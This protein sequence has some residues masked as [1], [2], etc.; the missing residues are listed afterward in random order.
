[1]SDTITLEGSGYP[2]DPREDDTQL[3]LNQL[4][5]YVAVTVIFVLLCVAIL[6]KYRYTL[7]GFV[8]NRIF[9]RS[10]PRVRYSRMEMDA[11]V[12]NRIQQDETPV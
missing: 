4:H 11:V 8:R 10:H 6:F 3:E 7:V 2:D 12:V 9:N 5:Y 1:M